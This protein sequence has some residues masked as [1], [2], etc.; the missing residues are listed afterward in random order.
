MKTFKRKHI[1]KNKRAES[2][3]YVDYSDLK[4]PM[5]VVYRNPSDFP[6]KII[7][8]IWEAAV[9]VPTNTYCEYDTLEEMEDDIK[10]L[11]Y[12]DKI[13]RSEQDDP[14]IVCSYFVTK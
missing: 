7:A 1:I 6:G 5:V 2:L 11:R 8:R 12:V 3:Y 13:P 14:C 10:K 4:L 9:N